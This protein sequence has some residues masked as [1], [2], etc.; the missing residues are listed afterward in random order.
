[1]SQIKGISGTSA[2]AITALMLSIGMTAKDVENELLTK[3]FNTF[4]DPPL[5]RQGR[6]LVPTPFEYEPIQDD[7]CEKALLSGSIEMAVLAKAI[8]CLG[9][10]DSF[11]ARLFWGLGWMHRIQGSLGVTAREILAR[12]LSRAAPNLSAILTALIR[13]LPH[14]LIYFDRDMGFFSGKAARDYFDLLLRREATRITNDTRYANPRTPSMPFI[15]H[16]K[17]FGTDLLICGANLSTGKSVLFSHK[18]TPNFP[19]ADAVRIS[20]S[21]PGFKPYVIRQQVPGWPPCGTYV[22]GG[23]WNNLPFREIGSMESLLQRRLG[24]QTTQSSVAML[25]ERRNT[26]GLRLEIIE[27]EPVLRGGDL[28]GKF[29][30]LG[31]TAGESQ[32]IADIEPF[33]IVLD[34]E[35]LDTLI[36]KPPDP[37]QKAVTK[38]ARQTTYRYFGKSPPEDGPVTPEMLKQQEE[39]NRRVRESRERKVCQ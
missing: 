31:L 37:I 22:D 13:G 9:A 33:T 1:M 11:L 8:Q 14:F 19:V 18:H 5:D 21:L 36:F 17:V 20:M 28:I 35:G 32:V 12:V 2:G 6:R 27:P 26:L 25:S 39:R 29:L 7:D 34:T 23:V 38:R 30:E 15:V 3:D 24:S 10:N 4:F 16:K